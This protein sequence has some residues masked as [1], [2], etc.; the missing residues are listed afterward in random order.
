MN[1]TFTLRQKSE[2]N[3]RI[4]THYKQSSTFKPIESKSNA[5]DTYN[6]NSIFSLIN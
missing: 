1:K 4:S 6:N 2:L 3:K 5:A